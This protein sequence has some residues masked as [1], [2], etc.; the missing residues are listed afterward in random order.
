MSLPSKIIDVSVFLN[1]GRKDKIHV[2][3]FEEMPELKLPSDG[4]Y[5][6]IVNDK[7]YSVSVGDN[8]FY[9]K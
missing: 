8:A 5:T 7:K 6:L 4:E 1:A 9:F 2:P 3:V